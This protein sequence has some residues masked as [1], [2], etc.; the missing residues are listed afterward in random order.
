M[1]YTLC[2]IEGCNNKAR[3][4]YK[5][6]KRKR[7]KEHKEIGMIDVV[8]KRCN[9]KNC[10]TQPSYNF[11]GEN[12]AIKCKEHKEVG[13]V[14]IKSK[15]CEKCNITAIFGYYNKPPLRCKEHKKE[16]MFN[17]IDKL[18]DFKNCYKKA[19]FN[20]RGNTIALRCKKH[21]E[22]NMIDIIHQSC[23]FSGCEKRATF[24][25]KNFKNPIKCK[26]HKEENMID[27][28]NKK[29]QEKDC[30]TIPNFNY[31]GEKNGI[32]CDKHKLEEMVNVKNIICSYKNCQNNA[33]YTQDKNTYFCRLHKEKNMYNIKIK[34]CIIEKCFEKAEYNYPGHNIIYCKNHKKENMIKNS[35]K[36]CQEKDCKEIAVFGLNKAIFCEKHKEEDHKNLVEKLC[37]SCNLLNI[38]DEKK[39]CYVCNPD[40]FNKVRLAKQRKI[41]DFFDINNI[42]Y[43]TYDKIYYQQ[44]G[45]ERPDF[46]FLSKNGH[47]VIIE[48][49][50]E[51][52]K[53]NQEICECSRM[54]NIS[55]EL[56][57]PTIFLRYNPDSY[58]IDNVKYNP[59]HKKRMKDLIEVLNYCLNIEPEN[60]KAYCVYKQLFFDNYHLNKKFDII[61]PFEKII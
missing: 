7:C 46:L 35:N 45:K 27:V 55:Q 43:E 36:K 53:S 59:S 44:C 17:I 18:C 56:N 24:N 30:E 61:T 38:V 29:C 28:I 19:N 2:N 54:I 23:D 20:F 60:L 3:Y 26:E 14:N 39:L 15:K 21:K 50:E 41:K 6:K 34:K 11:P 42:K 13:M 5:D 22:E 52:H 51:Q 9:E 40:N 48:V 8:E 49:D 1:G 57:S 37:K 33:N 4:N 31:K 16:D 58:K 47:F 25:F 10:F 32:R 12:K